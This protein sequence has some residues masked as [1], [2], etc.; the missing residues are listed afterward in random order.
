M[1][2]IY[3]QTYGGFSENDSLLFN[4]GMSDFRN[5]H[6]II[7]LEYGDTSLKKFK[8]FHLFIEKL[9]SLTGICSKH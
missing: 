9:Y 7:I 3:L 6:R 4:K 5:F 8:K 1:F 2:T